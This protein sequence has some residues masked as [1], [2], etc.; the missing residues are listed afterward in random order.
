ME[1]GL[2]W[3]SMVSERME[4]DQTGAYRPVSK[5][6]GQQQQLGGG[7]G[8]ETSVHRKSARGHGHPPPKGLDAC[9]FSAPATHHHDLGQAGDGTHVLKNIRVIL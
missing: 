5:K 2:E 1:G 9:E 8:P 7:Q 3:R 6:R 4:L